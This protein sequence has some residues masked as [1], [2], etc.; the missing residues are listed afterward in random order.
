MSNEIEEQLA[1]IASVMNS[2]RATSEA[3]I[4]YDVASDALVWTDELPR[5]GLFRVRELWCLRPV[6]RYRTSVIL[7]KPDE[8]Y[9]AIWEAAR[10][11]FPDWAGFELQR[12]DRV[13][14]DTFKQLSQQSREGIDKLFD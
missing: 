10:K 11:L 6:L 5:P 1:R 12:G 8:Q 2:L 4:S 9:R 3:Q 13:L 14:A 7:G